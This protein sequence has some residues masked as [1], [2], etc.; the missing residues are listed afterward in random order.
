MAENYVLLETISLT[1]S[2]ASVTFDNI[3]QTGY[4]DL[5]IVASARQSDTNNTCGVRF[6]GDT[7]TN[8]SSKRLGG[9]STLAY[10]ETSSATDRG[11]WIIIPFSTATANTFGNAEIYVPNY[12]SSTAKSYSFDSISENNSS[13]K[14]AAN[15]ELDAGLWSGTAAINSVT[16]VATTGF[17]A[18]ST[19][20]LYGIAATGTTPATAPKA[21]GGNIVANDGTYWYHAF[22]SSGTFTPQTA[23]TADVLVIA[24][25]GGGSGDVGGGGGAGG[26]LYAASKSLTTT[27]YTCTIG[28]GGNGSTQGSGTPLA[29]SGT[30]SYFDVLRAF[31]GGYGPYFGLNGGAGGS[32]GGASGGGSP[33]QT[34]GAST[35]TS[36]NGGTG[37]GNAG[38]N[39]YYPGGA[40]F[41]SAGGGGAGAVGA[42]N[43]GANAGGNGGA[44]L[45]TWSAWASAT[46]TGVSGYFAGGGGGGGTSSAGAGGAGGGG[47][48]ALRSSSGAATSG[49]I[50]TGGGGGGDGGGSPV[51]VGGSGGSGI[52]L[53]RYAMA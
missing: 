26:V 9:D 33:S 47:A 8:Y 50:N 42:N 29:T 7:G 21:T 17:V 31:G 13:A 25:G 19:F 44:G 18:N 32:G 37:Y 43:D 35:Q 45:N 30:D 14:D 41:S 48:G 23:L 3:P 20:S 4:T 40:N 15:M 49:T 2:A 5:K 27:S 10:S 34:G 24:G 1:Q 39:T 28:A 38:G 53:I 6:N 52:V 22:L 16:I 51:G 11:K 12:L 36:N 46:N